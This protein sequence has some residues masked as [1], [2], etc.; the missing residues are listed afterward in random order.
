[1][2]KSPRKKVGQKTS[3]AKPTKK[4]KQTAAPKA[5][6]QTAEPKAKKQTTEPKAKKQTAAPKAKKQTAEPKAKKQTAE[7][8]KK[9]MAAS[10]GQNKTKHAAA[11]QNSQS[12]SDDDSKY[13]IDG[14][15][16]LNKLGI[17]VEQDGY[18]YAA[19]G[20]VKPIPGQVR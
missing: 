12:T 14:I 5:K 3:A 4:G 17:S 11:A 1:M 10:R 7:P 16:N 20:T 2:K 15:R 19:D 18:I 9:Q 6:K 8:K 13:D